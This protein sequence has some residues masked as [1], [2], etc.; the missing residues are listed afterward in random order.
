E[1]EP[2]VAAPEQSAPAPASPAEV[3]APM[4]PPSDAQDSRAATADATADAA[5][6]DAELPEDRLLYPGY[7][8]GYRRYPRLGLA[9]YTPRGP[10]RP[11][12][13]P[14]YEAA[15]PPDQWTFR[16]SGFMKASLQASLDERPHT[17]DGQNETLFHVP[18]QTV[19]EYASFLST[20]TVPGNW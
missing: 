6:I 12:I 9:P 3:E 11:G 1:G 20:S 4:A 17:Q 5:A 7:V 10:S 13:A 2:S 15:I 19:E 14:G 18:P 16:F 8:P